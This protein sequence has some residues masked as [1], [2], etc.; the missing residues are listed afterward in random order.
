MRHQIPFMF[1]SRVGL[2]GTV[3]WKAP[4]LFG[5]NPRWRPAVILK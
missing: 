4:F 5:S 1:G 2:S 3:E